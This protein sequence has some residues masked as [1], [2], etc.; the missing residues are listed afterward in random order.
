[1]TLHTS[2]SR[3]RSIAETALVALA[4]TILALTW[5]VD[6]AGAAPGNRPNVVVVM[7]DDQDAKSLRVL[8]GVKRLLGRQGTTFTNAFATFPLCCP[9]RVSFLTGQYAHNHGVLD[10]SGPNGGYR[11]FRDFGTLPVSLNR[12]GYR[13]AWFG[14]Y[15]NG[16]SAATVDSP[17]ERRDIPPGWDRWYAALN[18]SYFGGSFNDDGRLRRLPGREYQTDHLADK[19]VGFIRSSSRLARPFFLTVSTK[20][21]HAENGPEPKPAPRH[22]GDF[23]GVSLPKPPSF[24]EQD[25]SDKPSFIPDQRLSAKEVRVL[26]SRHQARLETLLAVD[27]AVK[28][29]VAQLRDSRELRNTLVVFLSDNGLMN[30]QHRLIRKRTLYEE[31]ASVPLVI[32]GPGIPGGGQRGQLAANIDLAPTI[33]DVANARPLRVMDGRSLVPLAQ[34]SQAGRD[35]D[36]LFENG[37]STAVRTN[38][39]M[40]AEHPGSEVEL[41]HL[42]TDP[43][44]LRSRHGDPALAGVRA[45]LAQ[46]LAQLRNCAGASCR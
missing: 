3:T 6:Q 28:R 42:G 10:N 19:A 20:A 18:N 15:L 37:T 30:G 23:R 45:D 27:D 35:R 17:A 41:Y 44:Q 24:N 1:M 9:S 14:K 5:A 33:L 2:H 31:S 43:F 36:L 16:Y 12:A 39:Y 34:S 7:T 32:R 11:A 13:T 21:P 40:Y 38:R 8:K 22:E 4:L 26:R 25:V 29:I 46:R